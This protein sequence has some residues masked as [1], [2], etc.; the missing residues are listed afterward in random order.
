MSVK[1]TPKERRVVTVKKYLVVVI[2]TLLL[3]SFVINQ[4]AYGEEGGF[5][6]KNTYDQD[7][8]RLIVFLK[9]HPCAKCAKEMIG[10]ISE[11]KL[12]ISFTI[13]DLM[14]FDISV[15][16]KVDSLGGKFAILNIPNN[17]FINSVWSDTDRWVATHHEY[18]HLVQYLKEGWPLEK[19]KSVLEMPTLS[20][21]I[22]RLVFESEYDAELRSCTFAI[23]YYIVDK[24][25]FKQ[26]AVER[27]LILK[28]TGGAETLRSILPYLLSNSRIAPHLEMLFDLAATK[29]LSLAQILE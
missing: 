27:C 9:K 2:P 14:E 8:E 28:E 16:P 15:S 11:R 26:R 29:P 20:K 3:C 10:C 13:P 4:Y 22:A 25:Q 23:T 19:K 5:S 21:Q 7:T 1:P 6:K 24:K 12:L 17:F 18:I